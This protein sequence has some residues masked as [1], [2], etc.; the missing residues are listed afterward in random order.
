L[1]HRHRCLFLDLRRL[2][3]AAYP[4]REARGVQRKHRACQGEGRGRGTRLTGEPRDLHGGDRHIVR[5]VARAGDP[6]RSLAVLFAP[7][8]TRDDLFTLYAFNVE[9][10]RIAD[11][12][13]EP[14]LGAIRLQWWR[15]AIDTARNGKSTGHPVA[16]ALGDTLLRRAL[17]QER[18]AALIDARSFDVATKIMP[19]AATLDAYLRDTAGNLFALAAEIAGTEDRVIDNITYAA[20]RAYGLT[21]LMRALPVHTAKGR[22][23]LPADALQHHGTSPERVLAGEAS[24]G[25]EDLLAELRRKARNALDEAMHHIAKLDASARSALRPLCLV[26]PYL[27]ALESGDDPLRHIAGINP[28]YRLWRMVRWP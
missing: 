28:M 2:A 10:S 9:L 19:D 5:G 20:G 8:G 17:K 13:S 14:D 3:P 22:V 7:S 27:A 1:G 15:E 24:K 18:V 4:R 25:L 11:Q 26:K 12:V 16:D 21:G 6:D 23:F